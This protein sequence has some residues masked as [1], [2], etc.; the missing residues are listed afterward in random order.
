M[1][2]TESVL[3][4][5]VSRA[6]PHCALW[7]GLLPRPHI[8]PSQALE[9][10]LKST[11]PHGPLGLSCC[12]PEE[13]STAEE[14]SLL[15]CAGVRLNACRWQHISCSWLPVIETELNEL[16][17][18][19]DDSLCRPHSG[20]ARRWQTRHRKSESNSR[21]SV[22]R[23]HNP[24]RTQTKNHT[25]QRT[26][27]RSLCRLGE[28]ATTQQHARSADPCRSSEDCGKG[29]YG[30]KGDAVNSVKFGNAGSAEDPAGKDSAEKWLFC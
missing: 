21:V 2:R 14:T 12:S 5:T 9:L 25:P 16:S 29:I 17:I 26:R 6:L 18:S 19:L 23:H 8:I 22:K 1:P 13:E 10:Q 15:V 11:M 7:T 20:R 30:E 24:T 3:T 4:D 27:R 28:P